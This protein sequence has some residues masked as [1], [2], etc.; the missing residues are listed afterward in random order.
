MK[1]NSDSQ[2]KSSNVF[3]I[4]KEYIFFVIL[5]TF[6]TIA[7]S[8]LSL[9]IP[10]IIASAMDSFDNP[11]FNLTLIVSKAAAIIAGIFVISNIQNIL[12]SFIAEKVA[13]DYRKKI[14]KKISGQN[15]AYI[16]E[17][18]SAKLL[19][20]L[21]SDVNS[22]KF[23]IVNVFPQIVASVFLFI[24]AAILLFSTS[25]KLTLIVFSIIPF[26]AV[27]LFS[28]LRKIKK[29]FTKNQENI[30]KL[31]KTISE[32]IFAVPLIRLL[33]SQ[34][35]EV[36]K[37]NDV[38]TESRD[39]GINIVS[40]FANLIPTMSLLIGVIMIII[41]A[42]GGKAI[43]GGSMTI[44]DLTAFT[45]YI[46]VLVFP[47]IMIGF[48]SNMLAQ[49]EASYSRIKV[50]LDS[51]DP[52]EWGSNVFNFSNSINVFNVNLK[53]N[54]KNILK[55]VSFSIKKGSKVAIIGPTAA[56]KTQL[57]YLL[58]GLI[59]PT[60]GDI[61]FDNIDIYDYNKDSF[62]KSI[63]F[64]FQDSVIFN[65]SLREN[66]AFGNNVDKQSLDK[67]IKTAE[68]S[69]F[70]DSLDDGLDTIITER[71]SNLSGGQKQRIMLARALAI[72]PK[73]LFLDDFTARVDNKTEQKII[74]NLR[75]KYPDI[76]LISITQKIN[77][78]KDYDDVILLMEG[79]LLISGKHDE[80]LSK[81]PEYA[82][83][84]Q[85]QN[86]MNNYEIHA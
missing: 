15:Y 40:L 56:G 81:S 8:G 52:E 20:N 55:D 54:N 62:Y 66:I 3:G 64:V 47:M 39:I 2:N 30:D 50:I 79:E 53:L 1:N 60:S 58:S 21:T 35:Q 26:I 63:G 7:T 10:K 67:A 38:N 31:N 9:V 59:K 77:P 25:K 12:Q 14:M 51:A 27:L 41:V 72:N 19:T 6:L 65:L 43:M 17:K 71:G 80:L 4:L 73:I 33:N 16:Q 24:S 83:I 70:I 5:L 28:I 76:T 22:I 13:R 29:L 86:S 49:A 85:S 34:N 45:N 84:Y 69:D 82:Q 61:K 75:E 23:F 42:I 46:M 48:I 57:F 11:D 36:L 78:I 44:G 32:N 68:L 74:A 37:F 18:T